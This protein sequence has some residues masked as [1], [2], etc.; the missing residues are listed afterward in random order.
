MIS[1]FN[2]IPSTLKEARN[3]W[4]EGTNR[5]KRRAGHENKQPQ[6]KTKTKTTAWTALHPSS[7][8]LTLNMTHTHT[9]LTFHLLHTTLTE[10]KWSTGTYI[11]VHQLAVIL[12]LISAVLV[13]HVALLC[14]LVDV[15]RQFL[16]LVEKR[17]TSFTPWERAAAAFFYSQSGSE[18]ALGW[19]HFWS[20]RT[21]PGIFIMSSFFSLSLAGNLLKAWKPSDKALQG[22]LHQIYHLYVLNFYYSQ[23]E[24]GKETLI[25]ESRMTDEPVQVKPSSLSFH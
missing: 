18:D 10:R 11:S 6:T 22:I 1:C 12:H 19:W 23:W 17:I 20:P 16:P 9:L 25:L 3:S 4:R 2:T 13:R 7:L 5:K 14:V 8:P 21:W 15:C 24:A